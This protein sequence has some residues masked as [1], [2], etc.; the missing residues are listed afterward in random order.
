MSMKSLKIVSFTLTITTLVVVLFV[1]PLSLLFSIND[2]FFIGQPGFIHTT[3]LNKDYE[4]TQELF[5]DYDNFSGVGMSIKN[6]Q[7]LNKEDVIL[8]IF[9]D[10]ELVR[11]ST[12]SGINIP[13]GSLVKFNFNPINESKDKWY[14]LVISSPNSKHGTDESLSVFLTDEKEDWLGGV[15]INKVTTD[16]NIALTTHYKPSNRTESIN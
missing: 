1:Y 9:T 3:T 11:T 15:T 2:V 8:K 4:I 6:P 16:G 13:D 14:T 10:E 12:L 5:T 7:L